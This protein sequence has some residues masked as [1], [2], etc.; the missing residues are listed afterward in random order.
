MA[1]RKRVSKLPFAPVVAI[2]FA[3]AAAT[4]VL[5]APVWLLE[6]GVGK[7]G[8]ASVLPAAAPPLGGTARLLIAMLAAVGSGL[9][10]LVAM[11]PLSRRLAPKRRPA[12]EP[13]YRRVERE[14]PGFSRPPI[15]AGRDLGAPFM[16]DEALEIAPVRRDAEPAIAAEPVRD[17][18]AEDELVL[19]AAML[20]DPVVEPAPEPEPEAEPATEAGY[21]LVHAPDPQPPVVAEIPTEARPADPI[22]WPIPVPPPATI[23]DPEP[24]SLD[25]LVARLERGL[26][27]QAGSGTRRGHDGSRRDA[28]MAAA[29][30]A[31]DRR[32]AARG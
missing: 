5:A 27:R 20:A 6:R 15:F 17:L 7:V 4:L 2:L 1:V 3:I 10:T 26:A 31:I 28:E 8:L 9:V 16:S 12:A 22:H 14:E 25:E 11:I 23:A 13:S 24:E 29:L 18:P 21:E 30:R 19:D 32:V